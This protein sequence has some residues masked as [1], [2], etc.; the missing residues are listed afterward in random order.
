M[1]I[2]QF[3]DAFETEVGHPII[4]RIIVKTEKETKSKKKE[5]KWERN[6]MTPDEIAKCRGY[7][8]KNAN[9]QKVFTDYSIALKHCPGYWCVDVDTKDFPDDSLA[10]ILAEDGCY[11]TE[12]NKGF[13][14]YI[15]CPDVP[16]FTNEIDLFNDFQGD[17][18]GK[19]NGVNTWET[20]TRKVVGTHFAEYSWAQLQPHMNLQKMNEKSASQKKKDEL[21]KKKKAMEKKKKEDSEEKD[22]LGLENI[23]T[24]DVIKG[25]LARIKNTATYDDWLLVGCALSNCYKGKVKGLNL[26]LEWSK[27]S[28][29]HDDDTTETKYGTFRGTHENPA[30]WKSLRFLANRDDPL[31]RY[32]ALFS[33]GGPDALVK[34]MNKELCFNQQ[35]SEYIRVFPNIGKNEDGKWGTFKAN[36]IKEAFKRYTFFIINENTGKKMKVNPFDIWSE[37]INRRDVKKIAFDARPRASADPNIFNIW[38]GYAINKEEAQVYDEDDA[39]PMLDHIFNIWC[40]NRQDHYDYVMSWFAHI[41]QF[42]YIKIGTLLAL[43]SEQGAGKGIVFEQIGAIMGS[44][45]FCATASMNNILGDF[46]GGLEGKVLIDLDEAFWGGE[47]K[48]MGKM[49]NLITEKKQNVNKKNKE[50]YEIENTSAFSITTNNTLFAGVE[51]GDRRHCCLRLDDRYAGIETDESKVYVEGVRGCPSGKDVPEHIYGALAKVLYNRDLSGFRPRKIPRTDLLQ[52][53]IERGWN[54]VV[55]WWKDVLVDATFGLPDYDKEYKTTHSEY[56]GEMKKTEYITDMEFY[57]FI[58]DR[59]NGRIAQET[60]PVKK[61]KM[62]RYPIHPTKLVGPMTNYEDETFKAYLERCYM[63]GLSN[64]RYEVSTKA[65]KEEVVFNGEAQYDTEDKTRVLYSGYSPKWLYNTYTEAHRAGRL[66]HG[67]PETYSSWSKEFRKIYDVKEK[68][69][70]KD[71]KTGHRDVSWQV[72]D[73]DTARHN[74]NKSQQYEYEWDQAEELTP[75]M[76]KKVVESESVKQG[77]GDIGEDDGMMVLSSSD[78]E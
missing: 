76:G 16:D 23:P 55:R 77:L 60:Y 40:Q 62:M 13:H 49:K 9:S 38:Q 2:G 3:C 75:E 39:Q 30:G 8:K 22:P 71:K 78:E 69:H 14:F 4:R 72:I 51:K 10:R 67:K 44:A 65:V 32:E 24:D 11:S 63:P 27:K 41:L 21:K 1:N 12:T 31:N 26:W 68:K 57:P 34:E 25:F 73:L 20:K 66:G 46:N 36:Q 33:E 54:S 18:L 74:F 50:A 17:F 61:G 47:V 48:L 70:S 28:P 45:H 58:K 43:Q 56:S 5:P 35:T 52:D 42:P 29:K 7:D 53:Q 6:Q 64:D 37:H 15:K 59:V 19:S